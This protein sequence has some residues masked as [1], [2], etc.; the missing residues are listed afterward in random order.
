MS[1][2]P[3]G[4]LRTLRS[5]LES[6]GTCFPHPR[7]RGGRPSNSR[8]ESRPTSCHILPTKKR[9]IITHTALMF[10]CV[11]TRS[12]PYLSL[13]RSIVRVQS[14]ISKLA[15]VRRRYARDNG[16]AYCEREPRDGAFWL[17]R[18]AQWRERRAAQSA[19]LKNIFYSPVSQHNRDEREF[20][21][22][23]K[24]DKKYT[25]IVSTITQKCTQK[26]CCAIVKF[27]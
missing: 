21:Y 12:P 11:R 26:T 13:V 22:L 8:A 6:P 4:A 3:R 1:A 24:R 19:P 7:C 15:V 5:L 25:S 17:G 27:V 23:N 10:V 2:S 18:R 14:R 16:T 9:K 20:S